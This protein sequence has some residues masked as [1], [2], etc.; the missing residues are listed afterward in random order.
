MQLMAVDVRSKKF[1]NAL[2]R[3]LAFQEDAN[4]A[5][6]MQGDDALNLVDILDQ[7]SRRKII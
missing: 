5:M 1:P 2:A 4:T 7:V 6:P 3:I